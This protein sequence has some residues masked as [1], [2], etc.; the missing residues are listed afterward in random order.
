MEALTIDYFKS[1][2]CIPAFS[3]A[4]IRFVFMRE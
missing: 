3:H 4:I 2:D 1:S